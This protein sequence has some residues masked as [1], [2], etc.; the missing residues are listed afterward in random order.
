MIIAHGTAEL[1]IQPAIVSPIPTLPF[2]HFSDSVCHLSSSG[3]SVRVCECDYITL[4]ML[5]PVLQAREGALCDQVHSLLAALQHLLSAATPTPEITAETESG[6]HLEAVL[7]S[8]APSKPE[9]AAAVEHASLEPA[10][11]AATTMNDH[12]TRYA[13]S[14][15]SHCTMPV[16]VISCSV[17]L[18]FTD[19][20]ISL[21]QVLQFRHHSF[22]SAVSSTGIIVQ[23]QQTVFMKLRLLRRPGRSS[24]CV[25]TAVLRSLSRA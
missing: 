1:S 23:Q 7:N 20:R 4:V 10:T 2:T 22:A 13:S 11:G 8:G 18:Y 15:Q 3:Q 19:Q 6:I 21:C 12:M 16:F 24:G 9:V 5:G 25:A 17:S 14:V